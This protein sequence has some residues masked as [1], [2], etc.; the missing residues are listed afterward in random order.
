M[1]AKTILSALLLLVAGIQTTAAQGFR[2]YK[3]DGSIMQFSLR[4]DSIVFY[5]GIGSDQDFGPFTPVN[6]CIVGTWYKSKTETV[7]FN[8]DGT[9]DYIDGTTYEFMPYQGTIIINNASGMPMNILKV[10]KA[11]NEMLVV[12]TLGSETFSVWSATQPVK[13][14]TSIT[15]SP[16][17]LS[18]QPGEASNITVTVLPSDADDKSVEWTSSDKSV[19]YVWGF[20]GVTAVRAVNA[21]TCTLTCT[22]KDG[23]GVKAEFQ[24]TV[25]EYVEIGGL[26]W[27]T[28][29]VGALAVAGS[30]DACSGDYFAWGETTPRYTTITRTGVHAA[31]FTWR[32]GYSSGYSS[33]N[34]PT[35]TG[36]TL[37]ASH[38]AATA[39]WGS[40]WRTPTKAEFE[41]LAVACSGSS[42][43]P[44]TPIELTNTITQGGIYWLSSTQTIESAY[45]GVAGLL[46][47]SASDISKRVFFPASGNVSGTNLNNFG[48]CGS[49][50][51]SSRETFNASNAYYVFFHSMFVY[52]S[53]SFYRYSGFTV[54]PVSD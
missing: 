2:I 23:S 20:A 38:D 52:P 22:A 24:V 9:T 41:A 40:P 7:T 21:G 54:R 51:S 53:N 27:A 34:W 13:L 15:I 3:S 35:Y 49:Y 48:T 8:E 47:V 43:S 36:T 28:M 45:T 12:S 11:T 32:D 10:H 5:D 1:K 14:V 42:E 31:S 4:T 29:N 30:C 33:D 50:R 16:A 39:N 25:I 46:F 37:D 19:A 17:T 26:K 18:L 44:Q 6:Q